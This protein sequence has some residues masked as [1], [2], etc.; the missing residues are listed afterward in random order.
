[1]TGGRVR[2]RQSRIDGAA[3]KLLRSLLPQALLFALA[4][5][6]FATAPSELAASERH[7]VGGSCFRDL[8]AD[9]D[10]IPLRGYPHREGIEEIF[11]ATPD[12]W[13]GDLGSVFDPRTGAFPLRFSSAA[14]LEHFAE[15]GAGVAQKNASARRLTIFLEEWRARYGEEGAPFYLRR[16]LRLISRRI[17]AAMQVEIDRALA[18][19]AAIFAESPRSGPTEVEARDHD[20][21]D[22]HAA[23]IEDGYLDLSIVVGNAFDRKTEKYRSR[24]L[25]AEF[26][27][28]LEKLGFREVA[29]G[30]DSTRATIDLERTVHILGEP[31]RVRARLTGGARLDSHVRHAVANFI[32]GIAHADVVLYNGHSN[33]GSAYCFSEEKERWSRFDIGDGPDLEKKCYGLRGK[34]YQIFLLQSCTSY[35]RY[36]RPIRRKLAGTRYATR[37]GVSG[38]IGTADLTYFEDLPPRLIALIE[39]LIAGAPPRAIETRLRELRPHPE[40]PPLIVR[41]LLQ[42]TGTFIVPRPL[43]GSEPIAI[44]ETEERDA[45][46]GNRIEG[47]SADGQVWLDTSIF[48]QDR[49]G[50]VVQIV[51]GGNVVFGLYADGRVSRVGKDN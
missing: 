51:A 24:E 36:C 38:F 9:Q 10:G 22:F 43:E 2:D 48:P 42:R 21:R 44:V 6:I 18:R 8:G 14:L 16:S 25:L 39:G 4:S 26:F 15:P 12:L 47:R 31:V 49:P 37:P 27:H 34:P 33:G 3:T 13:I 19:R 35:D 46:R 11:R 29:A 41:G 23:L 30:E 20:Y 1:M 17:D 32:E 28:A 5:V 7:W 45:R 40:T 50:E